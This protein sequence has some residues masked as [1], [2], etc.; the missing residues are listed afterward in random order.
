LDIIYLSETDFF[1]CIINS[2]LTDFKM[3][4]H[5]WRYICS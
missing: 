1:I 2:A 4:F 5:R 3:V